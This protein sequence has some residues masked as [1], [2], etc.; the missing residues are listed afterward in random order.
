MSHASAL[1]GNATTAAWLAD[2]EPE[3][4]GV[5]MAC[6]EARDRLGGVWW[7]HGGRWLGALPSRKWIIGT[8][9]AEYPVGEAAMAEM[10]FRVAWG[11]LMGRSDA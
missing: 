9:E 6:R 5:F 8:C 1:F 10:P 11:W 4:V 7:M 2:I 3:D